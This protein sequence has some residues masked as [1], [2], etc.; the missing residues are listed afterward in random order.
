MASLLFFIDNFFI[1]NFFN[2]VDMTTL[3]NINF[4]IKE[5]TINLNKLYNFPTNFLTV[6]L[7]NYLFLTL[8]AAVKVTNVHYGPLRPQQ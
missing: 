4:L 3:P 1:N 2:N 6:L 8:I 5:N 7:I